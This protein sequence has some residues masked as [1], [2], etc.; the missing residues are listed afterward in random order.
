M[1]KMKTKKAKKKKMKKMEQDLIMSIMAAQRNTSEDNASSRSGS[2]L[3]RDDSER[4]SLIIQYINIK[5][6]HKPDIFIV[7][8]FFNQTPSGRQ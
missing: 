4:V 3:N 1:D 8:L 7:L 5:I 2:F 6:C